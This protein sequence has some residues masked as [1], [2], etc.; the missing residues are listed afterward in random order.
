MTN[1]AKRTIEQWSRYRIES[2]TPDY[3]KEKYG[4]PNPVFEVEGLDVD[5]FGKSWGMMDGN[6]ACL[7]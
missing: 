6:T 3:F 1:Q 7:L 5:V 4:G 2:G